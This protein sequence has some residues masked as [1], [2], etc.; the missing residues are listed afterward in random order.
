MGSMLNDFNLSPDETSFFIADTGAVSGTPA[1]L[2]CKVF[3]V[4]MG[5]ADA[6][7]RRLQGHDSVM[8][9]MVDINVNGDSPLVIA[10]FLH[11]RIGVDSIALDRQGKW[12]YYAPVSSST[13]WRVPAQALLTSTE[14]EVQASVETFSSK[15]I[16]DGISVDDEGNILLTAF[17]HSAVARVD[18]SSRNISVVFRDPNH[19]QWPD[20]LSFGP[21][22]WLY[23]TSSALHHSFSGRTVSDFAPFYIM[24]MKMD[25]GA[26]AG[27]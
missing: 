11:I 12:L 15:P 27:Q 2:A 6:C 8:P 17:E 3:A 23:V 10:S 22:N 20:G 14:A 4:E 5:L 13:L 24:R 21:S 25:I 9:E 19:L 18:A 1:L 16:T 26:A 7:K